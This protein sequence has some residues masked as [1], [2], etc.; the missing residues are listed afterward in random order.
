MGILGTDD[1]LSTGS[2]PWMITVPWPKAIIWYVVMAAC[3]CMVLYVIRN[4][5]RLVQTDADEV[6]HKKLEN[7]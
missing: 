2:C 3:A 1:T 5:F 4:I 6:A 7:F